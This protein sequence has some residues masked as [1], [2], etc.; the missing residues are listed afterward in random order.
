MDQK[1]DTWYCKGLQGSPRHSQKGTTEV[2]AIAPGRAGN[3][4]QTAY[5]F[6]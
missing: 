5:A 6:P 1:K 4:P 2:Q 3:W